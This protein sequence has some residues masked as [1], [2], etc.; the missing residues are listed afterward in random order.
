MFSFEAAG[1]LRPSFHK[2]PW[3]CF[4]AS[5]LMLLSILNWFLLLQQLSSN[6][7]VPY[8][9][10]KELIQKFTTNSRKKYYLHVAAVKKALA[11][12]ITLYNCLASSYHAMAQEI[13]TSHASYDSFQSLYKIMNDMACN[14]EKQTKTTESVATADEKMHQGPETDGDQMEKFRSLVISS[15]DPEAANS[16]LQMWE[17]QLRK[18]AFVESQY[19]HDI[20]CKEHKIDELETTV[21][22][23]EGKVDESRTKVTELNNLNQSY[24]MTIDERNAGLQALRN[25]PP[26]FQQKIRSLEQDVSRLEQN[27]RRLQL[28]NVRHEETIDELRMLLDESNLARANQIL[29]ADN[30]ALEAEY[31]LQQ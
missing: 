10:K 15:A 16:I 3:S 5:L 12:D 26:F 2:F 13:P 29:K 17:A 21:T 22:T 27:V 25:G 18:Q 19:K 14:E 9:F 4:Q 11:A 1:L 24:L 7:L 30:E 6:N 8:K 28:E 23:L 20:Q 31:R